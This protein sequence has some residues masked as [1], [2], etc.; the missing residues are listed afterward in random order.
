MLWR[1]VSKVL[2]KSL[3]RRTS[4][5][6]IFMQAFISELNSKSGSEMF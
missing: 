6:C 1:A 3:E 2:L 4:Y 5:A